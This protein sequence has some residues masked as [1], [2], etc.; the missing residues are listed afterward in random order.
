MN[1][2][3]TVIQTPSPKV[4]IKR[5]KITNATKTKTDYDEIT[6][7][8]IEIIDKAKVGLLIGKPARIEWLAKKYPGV[9]YK[10][11][12]EK[13]NSVN[14]DKTKFEKQ[15]LPEEP[16][17][18]TDVDSQIT[19]SLTGDTSL[20][21][22]QFSLSKNDVN[23]SFSLTFFPDKI[24]EQTLFDKIQILDIVEIYENRIENGSSLLRAFNPSRRKNSP[25][26]IGIVKSKKYVAQVTDGGI[27]RR[28]QVSGI[29]AAGLVSQF[30]LNLDSTAMILTKQIK[31]TTNLRTKLT[32]EIAGEDKPIK[33]V[34]TKVWDFFCELAKTNGTVAIK[35][36]IDGTN[37]SGIFD[38]DN[39]P[40]Y[41]P[42]A[43][44]ALGEQTQD[45]YSLIGGLTPEPIYERF[46]TMDYDSGKMKI[47]IR[48]V[49]FRDDGAADVYQN[50][51]G[52][53]VNWNGVFNRDLRSNEV[54][55]IDLTV[56]DKE[57]YT[58][59]FSY[60]NGYPIENDKLMKLIALEDEKG[61]PMLTFDD[62]KY[63]TYGYRPLIATFNGY[64]KSK[65]SND[66]ETE[67]NLAKINKNMREWFGNL[68]RMMSGSITL[69][70]TYNDDK[71][72]MPGE[73]VGFLG[74]QFY[75]EGISHS[76]NYGQGGDINLS[77]SRGGDYDKGGKFHPFSG[78]SEKIN[79]LENRKEKA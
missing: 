59:F 57:V 53:S 74:G 69:A 29:S 70:M 19:F 9:S 31:E 50:S 68:D 2:N 48:Q 55:S 39:S 64:D 37:I 5:L 58:V 3:Q 49:P 26:F 43:N 40:I 45:F 24:G 1:V 20:Q 14:G 44:L 27:V 61:N 4:V 7:I 13:I 62:K 78:I 75:V 76:W 11:V 79:L 22:Y 56:S 18:G 66:K 47:V 54:K 33:D 30:Y 41:Y 35:T 63:Q 71:P 52:K 12:Q 8:A 28:L 10:D 16:I 36:L 77:V 34:I 23:G 42:F 17:Y 65:K 6:K 21:S 25:V 60:L 67:S 32:A 51:K 38:C 73:V 46:A 15:A 72:I